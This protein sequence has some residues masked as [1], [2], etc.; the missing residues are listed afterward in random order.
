MLNTIGIGLYIHRNPCEFPGM[1]SVHPREVLKGV[2][3][4]C[5]SVKEKEGVQCYSLSSRDEAGAPAGSPCSL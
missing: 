5:R 1:S 4:G 3:E 2:M